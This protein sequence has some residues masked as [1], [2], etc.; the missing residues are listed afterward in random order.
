MLC[1]SHSLAA[2]VGSPVS[3][4]VTIDEGTSSFARVYQFIL[5]LSVLAI[6]IKIIV[7]SEAVTHAE[8]ASHVDD[9]DLLGPDGHRLLFH[10]VQ[11]K[12]KDGGHHG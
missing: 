7:R 1:V 12:H 2:R 11:V 3:C 10:T 6:C 9:E 5:E 8:Y 4:P